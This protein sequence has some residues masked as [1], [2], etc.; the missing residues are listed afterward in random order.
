MLHFGEPGRAKHIDGGIFRMELL[1]ASNP[2]VASGAT[3]GIA[4]VLLNT[5]TLT[6]PP[7]S[8]GLFNVTWRGTAPIFSTRIVAKSGLRWYSTD[9]NLK[10]LGH[11]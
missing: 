4:D 2:V 7:Y 6:A 9:F 11:R 8:G 1:A 10:M 3:V 5:L